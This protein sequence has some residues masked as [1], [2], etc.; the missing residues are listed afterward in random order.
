[1][2]YFLTLSFQ[3]WWSCNADDECFTMFP[4]RPDPRLFM[5]CRVYI[6]ILYVAFQQSD[7][8]PYIDRRA[9]N[10]CYT[11]SEK[12][13]V[14]QTCVLTVDW[15]GLFY[16]LDNHTTLMLSWFEPITD[17]RA[18]TARTNL[19][20]SNSIVIMQTGIFCICVNE[21]KRH[22]LAENAIQ[23]ME[24]FAKPQL[25]IVNLDKLLCSSVSKLWQYWPL[26]QG[27][28]VVMWR[29]TVRMAG[30]MTIDCTN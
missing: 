23:L 5:L 11:V 2:E 20:W 6:Y 7:I 14:R 24:R 22:W 13:E 8:C 4:R 25:W 27:I 1:M 9:S 30:C 21:D 17:S 15:F 26:Y 29:W 18:I 28:S 3:G 19:L 16:W 10:A 12:Q